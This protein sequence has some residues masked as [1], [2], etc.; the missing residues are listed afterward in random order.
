MMG[1]ALSTGG[2]ALTTNGDKVLFPVAS[3]CSM[4]IGGVALVEEG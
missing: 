4:G 1:G 2:V 3:L